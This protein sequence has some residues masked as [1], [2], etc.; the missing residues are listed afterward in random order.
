MALGF[1]LSY[2]LSTTSEIWPM[3]CSISLM[4]VLPLP[5]ELTPS[6][7]RCSG[8]ASLNPLPSLLNRLLK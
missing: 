1:R 3:V 4:P 7:S 8:S 5:E 2:S 6:Y